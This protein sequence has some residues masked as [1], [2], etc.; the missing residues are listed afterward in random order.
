MHPVSLSSKRLEL[1]EFTSDDVGAVHRLFSDDR[2][3]RQLSFDNRDREQIAAM[4]DG[5]LIRA[6][7]DPRV[8]YYLAVTLKD[9]GELVGSAR[10]GLDGVKAG[11]LGYSIHPDHWGHGY[12]TEAARAIIGFGFNQLQLHRVSAAI[13]PENSASLAVAE[14]LGMTLEGTIRDHVFTNGAWRD[15]I[16][17][18]VLAHEWAVQERTSPAA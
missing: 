11:K 13:G 2:V 1:R 7:A 15:S 12:A 9:S 4:L 16:L 6:Q 18:S 14:R 10:L 8:E 5:V 17:Y 3:T